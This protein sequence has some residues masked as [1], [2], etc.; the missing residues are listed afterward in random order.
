VRADT[1]TEL[2]PEPGDGRVFEQHLMPGIADA[3]GSGRVRLDAIARWLQDVAYADLLDA[4]A[5]ES[6]T[7]VIRRA[8]M[9]VDS[10]PRFG[11]P[12]TVRTF[13]SGIGRFS[14]ERRTS[15]RGDSAAVEAVALWIWIDAHS[16]RPK[17]F[18]PA[19]V[20]LYA[21]SAAGRDAPVRLRHSDPPDD[22][23]RSSWSFRATDE[24]VAGHVNNSHYWAPLE[25]EL[26][27]AEPSSIDVEIEYREPVLPGPV[28]LLRSA[29]ALWIAAEA[30]GGPV[31]ASIR[32]ADRAIG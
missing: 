30:E 22:C 12:V 29:D 20:E 23:E 15:V 4:G 11:E 7:W 6:G 14:A 8:R 28:A 19:F 32:I 18:P 3:G 2:V 16:G 24:D 27:G 9:R 21:T 25:Q 13:C 31:S 17:R 5:D 10:F 26:V 1:A